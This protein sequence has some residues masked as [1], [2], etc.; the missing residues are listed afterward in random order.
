MSDFP[1]IDEAM[2]AAR[3]L[4]QTMVATKR[5][6]N[7][8]KWELDLAELIVSEAFAQYWNGNPSIFNGGDK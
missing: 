3:Q 4:V 7:K 5:N 2:E 1:S 8:I 6:P